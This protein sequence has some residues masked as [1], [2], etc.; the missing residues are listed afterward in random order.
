MKHLHEVFTD[1]EHEQLV[2]AK[3]RVPKRTWHDFIMT[4]TKE[5]KEVK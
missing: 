3:N 4:L 5:E 2:K 1:Q